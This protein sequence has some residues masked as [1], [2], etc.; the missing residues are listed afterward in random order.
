MSFWFWKEIR[1][2]RGRRTSLVAAVILCVAQAAASSVSAHEDAG[3]LDP[4]TTSEKRLVGR[5]AVHAIVGNTVVI[6]SA[7]DKQ[8]TSAQYY[9]ANG[10]LRRARNEQPY[11]DNWEL[12]P[13]EKWSIR[14]EADQLCISGGGWKKDLCLGIVVTGDLVTLKDNRIGLI[15]GMLLKGDAR[16]LSP[17]AEKANQAKARALVGNTLFLKAADRQADTDSV[18][19]FLR[20][21]VGRAKRG[22]AAAVSI[23]W[24]LQL[25]GNLCIVE[26][27]REFRDNN[28]TSLSINGSAATLAAP[29]RHEIRGQILKGNALKI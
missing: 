11:F 3:Q 15:H 24:M 19:Y 1:L 28:C 4:A 22:Q 2:T 27:Q 29:D 9:M 21:G 7:G 13:E 10:K 17:A 8:E 16:G 23:K 14:E 26:A 6:L 12:Q 20:D 5:A 18:I 25:N